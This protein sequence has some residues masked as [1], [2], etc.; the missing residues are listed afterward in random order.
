LVEAGLLAIAP[1]QNCD[2]LTCF[3][4]VSFF[5]QELIDPVSFR[6]TGGPDPKQKLQRQAIAT[7][8][9]QGT[10]QRRSK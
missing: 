8:K 5:Y 6:R 7:D 4:H 10:R 9:T 1:Y 3:H 2:R